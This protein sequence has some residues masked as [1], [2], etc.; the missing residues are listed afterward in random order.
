MEVSIPRMETRELFSCILLLTPLIGGGIFVLAP[1]SKG[2]FYGGGVDHIKTYI[3]HL[4]DLKVNGIA[5]TGACADN[6]ILHIFVHFC[7]LDQIDN[8]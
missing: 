3:I 7:V 4:A 1:L 6:V 8:G 5:N 2:V